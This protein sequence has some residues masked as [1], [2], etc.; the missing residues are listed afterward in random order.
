MCD[1]TTNV[2]SV[3]ATIKVV[4][5]NMGNHK[6]LLQA[7]IKGIS[8]VYAAEVGLHNELCQEIFTPCIE[9]KQRVIVNATFYGVAKPFKHSNGNITF[10]YKNVSGDIEDVQGVKQYEKYVGKAKECGAYWEYNN[11]NNKKTGVAMGTTSDT[12]TAPAF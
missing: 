8:M 3:T 5:D 4:E 9:E 2:N 1:V 6:F 10:Y 11:N 7:Y 12:Q